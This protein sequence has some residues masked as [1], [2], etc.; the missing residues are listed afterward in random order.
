[1][2]DRQRDTGDA[3]RVPDRFPEPASDLRE[4]GDILRRFAA[5]LASPEAQDR[6]RRAIAERSEPLA[7]QV[8]REAAFPG[9]I[10]LSEHGD[11]ELSIRL[12]PVEGTV[13]LRISP[14]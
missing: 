1:M 8:A 7:E 13:R 3:G 5:H 6:M 12:G 10:H 2:T 4:L 14:S 11:V 9:Q